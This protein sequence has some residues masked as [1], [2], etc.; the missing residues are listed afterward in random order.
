MYTNEIFDD[1]YSYN[2]VRENYD[3]LEQH[4]YLV[5]WSTRFEP[6][7]AVDF[8]NTIFEEE[9]ELKKLNRAQ[10]QNS[11]MNSKKIASFFLQERKEKCYQLMLYK[12]FS[13]YFNR[14]FVSSRGWNT[15][16]IQ[17]IGESRCRLIT[18]E[19]ELKRTK[20]SISNTGSVEY[21][22]PIMVNNNWI[23]KRNHFIDKIAFEYESLK[24]EIH[25]E[26]TMFEIGI[27][28]C[29]QILD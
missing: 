13:E 22:S 6:C 23:E 21:F 16:L 5:M 17:I 2:W 7:E 26:N 14:F 28:G 24:K 19:F 10:T 4:K 20:I 27:R 18:R 8:L 25:T 12:D 29:Q 9:V 3:N 11:V 15:V 1:E